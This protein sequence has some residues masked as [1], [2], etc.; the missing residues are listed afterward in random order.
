MCEHLAVFLYITRCSPLSLNSVENNIAYCS[1]SRPTF[2]LAGFFKGKKPRDGHSAAKCSASFMLHCHMAR[3]FS[4]MLFFHPT[5][6]S[7]LSTTSALIG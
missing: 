1:K 5:R 7:L 3:A 2:R 6:E 4:T